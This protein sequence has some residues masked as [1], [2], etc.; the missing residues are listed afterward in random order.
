MQLAKTIKCKLIKPTQTKLDLL[1]SEW[2]KYQEFIQLEKE[3]LDWIANEVQVYS[4]YKTQA[5]WMWKKFSKGKN[6]PMSINNQIMKI[7]Q[8]DHKLSK[9]WARIPVKGRRGGIWLPI[10]PHKPFPEDY[11][12]GES[13][14]F[15]RK[16]KWQ[17]NITIKKEIKVRNHYNPQ[18]IIAIDIGEKITA[19]VLHPNGKPLFMGRQIRGI[20]RHYAWLRKRLGKKKLVKKIR[21]IGRRE[22]NKVNQMLHEISNDIVNLASCIPDS[23]IIIGDL[24]GI[25]KSAKGKGRRFNRIV[26][27]MVHNKLT[28]YIKYKANWEG[29]PIAVINERGTSKHCS[30]CGS[31]GTRPY[32]GLF[33]C[34]SCN[35]QCN[36]DHNGAKNIKKRFL[37]QVSGNGAV[38]QPLSIQ[39]VQA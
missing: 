20:R 35:Y 1:D 29:I 22:H 34:K 15:K 36:A 28:F 3:G 27:G 25:R 33:T 2:K 19:T 38:L 5:R 24:K 9:Y 32:Q 30:E 12:L 16:G 39:E 37:E 7:K 26:H 31:I 17:L 8:N 10:K 14:L 13:K 6:Q 18:N 11:K 21:Q 23:A 4:M